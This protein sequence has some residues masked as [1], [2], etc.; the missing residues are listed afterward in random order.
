MQIPRSG[1]SVLNAN[2]QRV[3]ILGAASLDSG[4]DGRLFGLV[5]YALGRTSL[6][7]EVD[8]VG[9]TLAPAVECS[10]I[11]SEVFPPA[12][13]HR[14]T[15]GQWWAS[16]PHKQRPDLLFC[17]NPAMSENSSL[18]M[19]SSE[20]PLILKSGIPLIVF[21]LDLDEAQRD[22]LI[23]ESYGAQVVTQPRLYQPPNPDV[24]QNSADPFESFSS[25][26]FTVVGFTKKP[27]LRAMEVA[28]QV[29]T[30]S[31]VL[32][33]IYMKEEY[34]VSHADAFRPC[35]VTRKGSNREVLHII[36]D[37]YLDPVTT[38]IF[39]VQ[40]GKECQSWLTFP[41]PDV[42]ELVPK[43]KSDLA[44]S[45][46]AAEIYTWM[47]PYARVN[48]TMGGKIMRTGENMTSSRTASCP[49]LQVSPRKIYH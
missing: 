31:S 28:K 27:V 11:A 2:Q 41:A 17:F 44:R 15:V 47:V 1:G 39:L 9:P 13:M 14:M 23:L 20:L 49:I 43:L 34:L 30:L 16:T 21:S 42:A 25:A 5:P 22:A 46:V 7:L 4:V 29:K 36:S 26:T 24:H 18:W 19:T 45:I 12:T 8:L 48:Q 32:V 37:I 40:E 38:E 3:A 33:D 35:A 6:K 10:E